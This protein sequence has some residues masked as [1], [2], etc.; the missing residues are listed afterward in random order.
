MAE[1]SRPSSPKPPEIHTLKPRTARLL[2]LFALLAALA[3]SAW[4][5]YF[6]ITASNDPELQERIERMKEEGPP[7]D[8][9][10]PAEEPP[11]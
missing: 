9:A 6:V 7:S 10:P 3:F 1:A 5:A 4:A 8:A 11:R 2:I